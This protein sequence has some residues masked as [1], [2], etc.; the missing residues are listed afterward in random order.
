MV[1]NDPDVMTPEW[2]VLREPSRPRAWM[3]G[4]ARPARNDAEALALLAAPE[5][6]PEAVAIVVTPEVTA[7]VA[8]L[9]GGPP[10]AMGPCD[11]LDYEAT[12]VSL[13]CHAEAPALLVVADTAM[14]GWRAAVDG[15]PVAIVRANLATRGVALPPG[16]HD[17]EMRFEPPGLFEGC[18]ISTL[19]L[20]VSAL[21]VVRGRV[22]RG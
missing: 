10:R 9:A 20:L 16:T 7:E 21:A 4:L 13:R 15:A 2:S 14:R 6:D 18:L 11:V 3:V 5:F 1:P 22:R 17:V 8:A 19:G 12:R